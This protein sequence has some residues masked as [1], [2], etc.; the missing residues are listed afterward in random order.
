VQ[1]N[2]TNVTTTTTA[3]NFTGNG[4]TVS[5]VSNVA[6]VNIPGIEDAVEILGNI[7]GSF[8]PN[9]ALASVQTATLIGNITLDTPI[10]MSTG[11]S[12]T[13]IFT[14]DSAGNREL[15]AN[16]AYKFAG[17][18]RTLSFTGNSIDML[19]MF[20]DGTVYYV[21]LTTGYA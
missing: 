1:Q 17:N 16:S 12:L 10:N 8:A 9:R 5:N 18:F 11:Q 3:L 19:N 4:V 15:T 6:T 7:S 21:A 20:Y 2:A 13:L 14:Q